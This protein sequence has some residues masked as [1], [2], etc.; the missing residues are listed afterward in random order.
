MQKEAEP[1]AFATTCRT[2]AVH[3]VVPVAGADER[4]AV[5]ACRE[6]FVD[7]PHAVFEEGGIRRRHVRPAVRFVRI[8]GERRR[9]QEGHALVQDVRVARR[10]DIFRDDIGEPQQ[11]VRAA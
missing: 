7:G 5:R 8:S 1:G 9:L 11:V 2:H 3:A 4:Q 6:S 10:A